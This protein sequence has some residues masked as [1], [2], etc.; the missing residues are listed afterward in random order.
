[1]CDENAIKTTADGRGRLRSQFI[2]ERI[3]RGATNLQRRCILGLSHGLAGTTI[4]K[5]NDIDLPLFYFILSHMCDRLDT[6]YDRTLEG[7]G[8]RTGALCLRQAGRQ[9]G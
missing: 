6:R 2:T 5:Q 1:M 8:R 9:A 4:V 7:A 3:K